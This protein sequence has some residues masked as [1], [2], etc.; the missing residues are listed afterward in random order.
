VE[1]AL[2]DEEDWQAPSRPGAA[3]RQLPLA[4]ERT[5]T[6]TP[7][8]WE[9]ALLVSRGLTNRRIAEELSISANT[10]N[11]HVAKILH[12]LGLSSR[13]EIATWVTQQQRFSS[14]EPD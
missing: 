11:N 10:A 9:V 5:G 13:A 6:L 7:R 8:E 4:G 14:S 2:S 1:Y 3:E 12:K